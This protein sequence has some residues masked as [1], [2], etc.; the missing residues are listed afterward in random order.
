MMNPKA[1][2]TAALALVLS[3]LVALLALGACSTSGKGSAVDAGVDAHKLG[4]LNPPAYAGDFVVS[5]AATTPFALP[6]SSAVK[7]P[8][9][10]GNSAAS[11]YIRG[12]N[13]FSIWGIGFGPADVPI[14]AM[15]AGALTLGDRTTS[16]QKTLNATL[17][18]Y[19]YSQLFCTQGIGSSFSISA[20]I[21]SLSGIST[22]NWASTN[23][24]P[25]ISQ[26]SAPGAAQQM[27]VQAQS[28]GGTNDGGNLA[29]AGGAPAGSGTVYGRTTVVG[30]D[31][32]YFRLSWPADTNQTISAA[33]STNYSYRLYAGTITAAR[34]L[35]I[36]RRAA[37]PGQVWIRNVTG[38]T[39]TVGW[40]TGTG[41]A[42]PTNTSA[43][44][45]SDGTNAEL[46]AAGT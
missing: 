28:A 19:Q 11:G 3:A 35:T 10:S 41:I 26:T 38:F 2:S 27:L 44:I 17:A 6:N 40:L 31:P 12:G 8:D 43:L 23:V 29:L 30:F 1:F 5:P 25:T 14:A 42:V 33:A 46:I 13:D 16:S 21:A 39:I 34:A 24:A 9:G 37:N 22:L 18:G 32:G 15:N 4:S 45:G 36:S 7:F 20:A